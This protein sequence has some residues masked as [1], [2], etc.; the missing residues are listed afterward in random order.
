[1]KKGSSK[2]DYESAK[3][4]CDSGIT[5]KQVAINIGANIQT[6]QK[7][8][9]ARYGKAVNLNKE[10]AFSQKQRELLFGSL[11]GDGYLNFRFKE[12]NVQCGIRFTEEHGERQLEYLTFKSSV[13]GDKIN[14]FGISTRNRSDIR[15]KA[16]EYKI[17]TLR[18]KA[19]PALVEFYDLFYTGRKRSMPK[20]LSLLTPFAL[21]V[22]YMD[23][24]HKEPHGYMISMMSFERPDLIRFCEV[25]KNRYGIEANV[26]KSKRVYIPARS[27]KRFTFIIENY[28]IPCMR[29]KLHETTTPSV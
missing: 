4:M 23:D 19:N 29:Y 25:L 20:D 2:I 5:R 24:G 12:G 17:H 13:F 26:I 16:L 14:D 9:L 18:T 28:I 6:F 15:F 11:L 10:C 22:L 8:M 27:L 3:K 1:M 21:A 7:G